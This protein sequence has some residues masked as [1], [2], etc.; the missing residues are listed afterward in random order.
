VHFA[1]EAADAGALHTD[2]GQGVDGAT[3]P[4][5]PIALQARSAFQMRCWGGEVRTPISGNK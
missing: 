4:S 2:R 1:A 5:Q 3:W